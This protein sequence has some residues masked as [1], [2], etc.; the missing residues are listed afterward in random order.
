[1]TI[2][3]DKLYAD[4]AR[5]G[6]AGA[7]ADGSFHEL[8]SGG[9]ASSNVRM[10]RARQQGITAGKGEL[11]L[12]VNDSGEYP[13]VQAWVL[14]PSAGTGY[15]VDIQAITPASVLIKVNAFDLGEE[16]ENPPN[17]DVFLGVRIE[18]FIE[19]L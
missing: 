15:T 4:I 1:M 16:V 18:E 13:F 8:A 9:G 10:I 3:K 5:L 12:D 11:L 17:L 7:A 6:A 2:T 19:T 14:N